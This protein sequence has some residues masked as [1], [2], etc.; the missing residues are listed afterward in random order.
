MI[1]R[2]FGMICGNSRVIAAQFALFVAPLIALGPGCGAAKTANVVPTAVLATSAEAQASLIERRRDLEHMSEPAERGPIVMRMVAHLER[3]K[4][5]PSCD[6]VRIYL[7][8]VW[9]EMGEPENA[10]GQLKQLIGLPPG[11][12]RDLFIVATAKALRLQGK[13]TQAL[14][15]L[16]PLSGK[17]VDDVDRQVFVEELCQ[18]A[19]GAHFDYEAMAYLDTWLRNAPGDDRNRVNERVKVMLRRV[20]RSVLE[21]TLRTIRAQP[22]RGGYSVEFQRA[23]SDR[24]AEVAVLEGDAAL[25]R[26]LLEVGASGTDMDAPGLGQLAAS[27][28]GLRVVFGRTVGLLVTDGSNELRDRSAEV[29]RGVLWALGYGND[30]SQPRPTGVRLVTRNDGGATSYAEAALEEM[31]GEGVSLVIAGI[32]RASADRALTWC[33]AHGLP[34]ILLSPA[35]NEPVRA[36]Y[37]LGAN[38]AQELTA[39]A[40]ALGQRNAN[41]LLLVTQAE[42]ER[43]LDVGAVESA[44]GVT[45][46]GVSPCDAAA[47]HPGSARFP[48]DSVERDKQGGLLVTGSRSCGR[49]VSEDA[50]RFSKSAITAAFTLDAWPGPKALEKLPNGSRVLV[51][52]AGAYP[53]ATR[54]VADEAEIASYTKEYGSSPT[55]WSSLGRDAGTIATR[56]VSPLPQDDARDDTQ[57][58]Q[59][60]A[61]VEAGLRV[62]RAR[63]WTTSAVGFGKAHVIERELTTHT[64]DIKR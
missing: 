2:A 1:Q 39:L 34:L 60:R 24:L 40:T 18:A 55:W 52:S 26:W 49:A 35:P 13:N 43:M 5:D 28:R 37:L 19:I 29:A 58:S 59:R 56:A 44:Q 27:R 16:R 14:D 54:A 20:D 63:L 21:G 41:H 6:L 8:L 64:I 30:T 17:I 42:G 57:V 9:L 23:L 47:L 32:D 50:S 4:G 15:L 11:S 33:E 22:Q 7:A 38:R 3:Y 10:K 53:F 36:G 31:A 46:L 61:V 48:L 12:T 51:T 25:A 62:V 45:L